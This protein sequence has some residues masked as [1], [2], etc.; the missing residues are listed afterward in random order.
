MRSERIR[1]LGFLLKTWQLS[2]ALVLLSFVLV[3]LG[4][5]LAP[6]QPV[7]LPAEPMVKVLFFAAFALCA[8]LVLN[9]VFFWI[10][11][12]AFA[13]FLDPRRI[14][15]KVLWLLVITFGLSYGAAAY[16]WFSARPLMPGKP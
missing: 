2:F 11:M 1:H 3:F 13:L 9:G 10:S 12:I 7:M 15:A 8:L 4:T 16:Y 14:G 6:E 5:I